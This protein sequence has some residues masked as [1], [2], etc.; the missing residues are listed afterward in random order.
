MLHHLNHQ[1][2]RRRRKQNL[3]LLHQ[4]LSLLLP[5]HQLGL[6]LKE[7]Q[8][9]YLL[10]LQYHQLSPLY[11]FEIHLL[12]Q[13]LRLLQTKSLQQKQLHMKIHLQLRQVA[14]SQLPNKD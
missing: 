1:I 6:F 7:L 13:Q 2:M 5:T 11:H 14:L 9:K 4:L 8:I 3:H 10:E 12:L